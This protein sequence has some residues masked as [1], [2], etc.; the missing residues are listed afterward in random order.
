[1]Q[2]VEGMKLVCHE[3]NQAGADPEGSSLDDISKDA[4][5]LVLSLTKKVNV[6][7]V[8]LISED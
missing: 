3:L 1:M 7:I 2:A 8:R 6:Q 4:D 5:R